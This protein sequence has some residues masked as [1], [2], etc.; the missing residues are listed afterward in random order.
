MLTRM[1]AVVA[2][3]KFSIPTKAQ[4]N[5]LYLLNNSFSCNQLILSILQ[6]PN[7]TYLSTSSTIKSNA[8]K[9]NNC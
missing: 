9:Q 1:L 8:K 4:H 7:G 2:F 6:N 5:Y 3:T